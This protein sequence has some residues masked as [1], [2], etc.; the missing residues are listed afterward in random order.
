MTVENLAPL[1]WVYENTPRIDKTSVRQ[2]AIWALPNITRQ[3][4]GYLVSLNRCDEIK[5]IF[6][7]TIIIVKL[8]CDKRETDSLNSRIAIGF[9][10]AEDLAVVGA[11]RVMSQLDWHVQRVS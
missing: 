2:N 7:S 6:Y 1:R 5:H 8:L 4:L 11:M 3:R 10:I 9:L